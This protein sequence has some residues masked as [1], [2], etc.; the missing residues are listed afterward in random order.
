MDPHLHI[1]TRDPAFIP[2]SAHLERFK[3]FLIEEGVLA[4]GEDG[5]LETGPQ[6]GK[7]VEQTGP[8][9]LRGKGQL[10]A[11]VPV[12]MTVHR[13]PEYFFPAASNFSARCPECSEPLALKAW[14]RAMERWEKSGKKNRLVL[15]KGCEKRIDL[16]DLTY[17]SSRG[18]SRF[19]V[20]I[21]GLHTANCA[22]QWTYLEL[23]EDKLGSSLSVVLDQ[24]DRGRERDASAR[25]KPKLSR[26]RKAKGKRKKRG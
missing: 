11:S 22:L 16:N 26:A 14:K 2:D 3:S 5:R 19:S 15:C 9:E 7:L 12:R 25:G 18:F 21:V 6:L 4:E 8:F 10:Q 20:D 1:I 23:L 13:E 24:V 17:A